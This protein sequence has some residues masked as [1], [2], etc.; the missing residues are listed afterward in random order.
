VNLYDLHC[1]EV[2]DLLTDYL[3]DTLPAPDRAVLEEHLLMCVGC[4]RYLH[5]LRTSIDLVGRLQEE[6]VP[7]PL[8]DRLLRM[9]T[10]R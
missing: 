2:V 8:K 4:S 7:E 10:E 6:D 1:R 5:Q 3:E 9:F